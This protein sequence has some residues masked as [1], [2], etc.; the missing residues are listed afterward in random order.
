MIDIMMLS[1]VA[2]DISEKTKQ[3]LLK[4]ASKDRIIFQVGD[5]F[6]N[7]DSVTMPVCDIIKQEMIVSK[8]VSDSVYVLDDDD[9]LLQPLEPVKPGYDGA[10]Y[11]CQFGDIILTGVDTNRPG[12]AFGYMRCVF[13]REWL[14]ESHYRAMKVGI[15]SCFDVFLF[16]D[17]ALNG[18]VEIRNEIIGGIDRTPRTMFV[19]K[20][21]RVYQ[22]ELR[23]IQTHFKGRIGKI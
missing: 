15:V 6:I 11:N 13:D 14:I 5:D 21:R 18:K 12:I 22:D 8:S 9:W 4:Y 17:L 23:L 16:F 19:R 20:F 1:N 2:W 10:I 3:S 7:D